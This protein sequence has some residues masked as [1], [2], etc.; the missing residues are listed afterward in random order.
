MPTVQRDFGGFDSKFLGVSVRIESE[1]F[2]HILDELATT[3]AIDPSLVSRSEPQQGFEAVSAASVITHEARHFHDFLIAP[4][5]AAILALRLL[6]YLNAIQFL[7][8]MRDGE[9]WKT[10]NCLPIPLPRWCMKAPE[11]R[12]TFMGRVNAWRESEPATRRA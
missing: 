11:E 10:A 8:A 3:G 5:G 6:A 4:A 12:D 1:R 7:S 9:I 2:F